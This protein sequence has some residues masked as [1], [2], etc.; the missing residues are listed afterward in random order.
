MCNG[1]AD[2]SFLQLLSVLVVCVSNAELVYSFKELELVTV[3][4]PQTYIISRNPK[5]RELVTDRCEMWV[6]LR[7]DPMSLSITIFQG[8]FSHRPRAILSDQ[9]S[10]RVV[11]I[12]WV[13]DLMCICMDAYED[14][15][16]TAKR[17]KNIAEYIRNICKMLEIQTYNPP[18]ELINWQNTLWGP[19]DGRRKS[20]GAI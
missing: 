3:Y 10:D 18:E 1:Q 15:A 16:H 19:L 17:N 12:R 11:D 7:S 6:N 14:D 9:M 20:F 8:L 2:D 5:I 4:P 13:I